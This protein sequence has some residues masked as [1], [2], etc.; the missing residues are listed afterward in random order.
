MGSRL[1]YRAGGAGS[2]NAS[3]GG[4]SS[5]G[6]PESVR[7]SAGSAPGG[8]G[9][10]ADTLT[11]QLRPEYTLPSKKGRILAVG[12]FPTNTYSAQIREKLTAIQVEFQRITHVMWSGLYNSM[13]EL[14]FVTNSDAWDLKNKMKEKKFQFMNGGEQ[15]LTSGRLSTRSQRSA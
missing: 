5:R 2:S 10:T 14:V 1:G 8:G 3:G 15:R 13:G 11:G 9:T 4:A 7:S 12:G 6:Y